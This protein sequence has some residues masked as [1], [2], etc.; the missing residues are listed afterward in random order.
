MV[1]RR[2]AAKPAAPAAK[3]APNPLGAVLGAHQKMPAD[4]NREQAGAVDTVDGP[5]MGKQGFFFPKKKKV[6]D[7]PHK[8][9]TVDVHERRGDHVATIHV[10]RTGKKHAVHTW[11]SD[12]EL[13]NVIH[14]KHP[15]H[16]WSMAKHPF[17]AAE[18]ARDR[19][20]HDFVAAKE[21]K[22][23]QMKEVHAAL[24][25]EFPKEAGGSITEIMGNAPEYLQMANHGAQK[26][27]GLVQS[28][29]D[30]AGGIAGGAAVT[31]G[32]HKLKKAAR[33]LMKKKAMPFLEQDRPAKVKEIYRA[34]ERDHPEYSAEKKA[35]I[36]SSRGEKKASMDKEAV[37][38]SVEQISKDGRSLTFWDGET[39]VVLS[40]ANPPWFWKDL[41]TQYRQAVVFKKDEYQGREFNAA[42]VTIPV[43]VAARIPAFKHVVETEMKARNRRK[44]IFEGQKRSEE[45][46]AMKKESFFGRK[47][48]KK[49]IQ[50]KAES[51][52][53]GGPRIVPYPGHSGGLPEVKIHHPGDGT[54]S[55]VGHAATLTTADGK[56]HKIHAAHGVDEFAHHFMKSKPEHH[57]SAAHAIHAIS[58]S[59]LHHAF[60]IANEHRQGS[61]MKKKAYLLPKKV[62]DKRFTEG[63][64]KAMG[65]A[66]GAAGGAYLG[67]RFTRGGTLVQKMTAIPAGAVLGMAAGNKAGKSGYEVQQ[68]LDKAEKEYNKKAG[69]QKKALIQRTLSETP[70]HSRGNVAGAEALAASCPEAE[71]T[72]ADVNAR[73]WSPS[74]LM[75]SMAM[76]ETGSF[77]TAGFGREA[78]IDMGG[79]VAGNVAG[80]KLTK[81][82][83]GESEEKY[84]KRKKNYGRAGTLAGL[85]GGELLNEHIDNRQMRKAMAAGQSKTAVFMAVGGG[86]AGRAAGRKL[87]KK[88]DGESHED[89]Q[90]RKTKAGRIG[91][92][93]GAVGGELYSLRQGAKLNKEYAANTSKTA[94]SYVPG[95]YKTQRKIERHGERGHGPEKKRLVR[96]GR[97]E[98]GMIGG[99][100][101]LVTGT[102][103]GGLAGAALGRHLMGTHTGGMVGG[104]AGGLAGMTAGT[105]L[106][107]MAGKRIGAGQGAAE[108]ENRQAAVVA[109][110]KMSPKQKRKFFKALHQERH[111]ED[112]HSAQ[113][114]QAHAADR[115]ASAM[116]EA[117]RNRRN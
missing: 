40:K 86:L 15:G 66:A 1:R 49:A 14:D 71:R 69:L 10:P 89:F 5:G 19:A 99:G 100:M 117:N 105:H 68:R 60:T 107:V 104:L 41:P 115:Q 97:R 103:G 57:E 92:V 113:M 29:P 37:G 46:K 106:G 73:N 30:L 27:T 95:S 114:Y 112:M 53:Q 2:L 88:K 48:K 33:K 102:A 82:K 8:Y 116:E 6:P 94:A 7:Y 87:T 22:H 24:G 9:P 38:V 54:G 108:A 90:K 109:T 93:A 4:G 20:R 83:E 111:M 85:I 31:H 39:G 43:H 17:Q 13:Y 59:Q 34:L 56:N 18:E 80:R 78:A 79:M 21:K 36:A 63:Q 84:L 11:T 52:H 74:R 65:T 47:K 91:A 35:R 75:T 58:E 16:D 23:G 25:V 98:G 67:N 76:A 96:K 42:E 110:S 50:P 62:T 72:M 101:G 3:P 55:G 70:T 12:D 61:D 32:I 51:S 64:A 44:T 77:K 45:R 28:N 26:L 81:K